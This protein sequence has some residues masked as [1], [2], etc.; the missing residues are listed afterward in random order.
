MSVHR[1]KAKT[2]LTSS[3]APT[4]L[5]P[6]SHTT[7]TI[8][9]PTTTTSNIPFPTTTTLASTALFSSNGMSNKATSSSSNKVHKNGITGFGLSEFTGTDKMVAMIELLSDPQVFVKVSY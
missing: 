8:P 4:L 9:L 5:S 6:L 1:S 3:S 7:G 2:L